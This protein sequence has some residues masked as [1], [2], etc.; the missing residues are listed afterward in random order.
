MNDQIEPLETR[1]PDESGVSERYHGAFYVLRI[2]RKR[3]GRFFLAFVCLAIVF[4][5]MAIL[6]HW[7]VH[8]QLYQTTKQE[9]TSW[10]EQVVSEIA[11]KDKWD[12]AGYR[13]AAIMVPGW[14]VVTKNGLIV[15]IEGFIPGLF[16]KVELPNERIFDAPQ[17]IISTI[18]ETW[19]LFGRK[20]VGGSVIIGICDPN[21]V[22]DADKTLLEYA[23]KFGSTL[24]QAASLN[25]REIDYDIEYAVITSDGE[26]KAA[27]GGVPIE[28]NPHALPISYDHLVSL[29]SNSKLYLLYCQ[30]IRDSHGEEVGTVILPKEMGLE[31]EALRIQDKFNYWIVGIAALM[32]IATVLWLVAH[33]FFGQTKRVTLDE[34][35]K[36]GESATIEFKSSF[37]WDLK[38]QEY[39]EDRRLDVLKSIAG[40]LN[41]KGGTLFIGVTEDKDSHVPTLCGLGKDLEYYK[42]SKDKLQQ[43]LRNLITTRIGSQ[44]SCFIADNLEESGGKLYWRVVVEKSPEPA[45]VRW[46]V[47]GERQEQKKFYVREGPKTSDLDNE[48]TWRYIKNR[49]G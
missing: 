12:L 49:W 44:F 1:Q 5:G 19:R 32:A 38:L 37:D 16:G 27:L 45:F 43:T 25:P 36:V 34:A 6:Q 33:N 8:K 31:Q 26:L 40:F 18:G 41:A 47:K 35:L 10:A 14:F 7:F 9:L 15:D 11:Y 42:G 48:N 46:K 22:T 4:A 29:I 21:N 17:T 30:P 3:G 2:L 28:T 20:V 24:D 23:G 13:R 39:H